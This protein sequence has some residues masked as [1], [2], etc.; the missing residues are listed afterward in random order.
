[1]EQRVPGARRMRTSA[2]T[3]GTA[4]FRATG[5]AGAADCARAGTDGVALAMAFTLAREPRQIREPQSR[6]RT[7]A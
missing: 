3:S 2:L 6:R 7:R 4:A 5:N 1:M